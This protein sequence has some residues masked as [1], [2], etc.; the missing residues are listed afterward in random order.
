M[1]EYLNMKKTKIIKK[2]TETIKP[3]SVVLVLN[4]QEYK[5]E[6]ETFS[7]SVMKINPLKFSTKGIL[8]VTKNGKTA[9]ILMNI[10]QMK[11]LFGNAGSKTQEIFIGFFNNRVEQLLK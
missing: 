11:R 3:Y 4:N 8:R 1:D 10:L 9:Q 6:G 5:S 2:T 7:E